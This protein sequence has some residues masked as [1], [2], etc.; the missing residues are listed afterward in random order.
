VAYI[1]QKPH[2][3]VVYL[4]TVGTRQYEFDK[5][6]PRL[7]S[8]SQLLVF[9][10]EAGPSGYWL[11]RYLTKQGHR[12]WVV[13]PSLVPKKAGDRVK[14]DRHDAIPLARLIRAGELTPVTVPTVA[15][16]SFRDLSHAREETLRDLKA[17]KH[18][19]KAFPLP[20]DIRYTGRAPWGA[21]HLRCLSE[22]VCPSPGSATAYSS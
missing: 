7:L 17:A 11:F 15:D 9:V 13:A 22:V 14:T 20:H 8:K 3:E 16:E 6:I 1:A 5:L 4:G 21:A 2:A 10:Y 12:C 19:L 18:R